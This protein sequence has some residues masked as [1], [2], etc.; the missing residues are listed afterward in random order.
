MSARVLLRLKNSRMRA[1]LLSFRSFSPLRDM[2]IRRT[3]LRYSILVGLTFIAAGHFS[4]DSLSG[5]LIASS[6]SSPVL[7]DQFRLYPLDL[8]VG[9]RVY[10]LPSDVQGLL[11]APVLVDP[12]LDEHLLEALGDLRN[13]LSLSLRASSPTMA[14]RARMSLPCA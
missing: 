5:S 12:L 8:R 6:S 9:E 7:F 13:F 4:I 3:V 2:A 10:D 14:E 1:D 11:D